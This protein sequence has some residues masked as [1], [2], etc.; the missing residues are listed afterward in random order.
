MSVIMLLLY[1]LFLYP[2]FTK[3][4]ALEAKKNSHRIAAQFINEYYI[5]NAY[6]AYN[7]RYI[8]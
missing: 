5:L 6:N 8:S 7:V 3:E 1:P 2:E 4:I